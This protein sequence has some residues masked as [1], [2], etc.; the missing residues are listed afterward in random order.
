MGSDVAD[1][2]RHVLADA[3]RNRDGEVLDVRRCKVRVIEIA[4]PARSGLAVFNRHRLHRLLVMGY[5]NTPGAAARRR[6]R[7]VH[8]PGKR[9]VCR[10]QVWSEDHSWGV[11]EVEVKIKAPTAALI[12]DLIT[13]A[14]SGPPCS[15]PRKLPGET[16]GRPKIIHVLFVKSF[17]RVRRV[18]SDKLKRRQVA[19]LWARREPGF[20]ATARITE[21]GHAST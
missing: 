5:G 8:Q 2:K 13:A 10:R 9:I 1:V 12:R 7:E 21:R 18:R 3:S 15:E 6:I 16:Y 4:A 11:T 14:E 19:P 20:K 17:A